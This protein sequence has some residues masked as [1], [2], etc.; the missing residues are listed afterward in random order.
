MKRIEIDTLTH[1]DATISI[2]SN[3]MLDAILASK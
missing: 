1:V 2:Q 3:S